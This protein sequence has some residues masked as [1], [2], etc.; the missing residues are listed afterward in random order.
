VG[1]VGAK[2]GRVVVFE[3]AARSPGY[4]YNGEVMCGLGSE[5]EAT[6]RLAV[7]GRKRALS[8]IQ[9]FAALAEGMELPP[10]TAVA[11]AA[12][13]QAEDGEEFQ[14]E[15]ERD[16]GIALHVIDGKEE[17]RLSAQGVLL[18]W[19]GAEGLICDIGGSSMEV[20]RVGNGRVWERQTSKL[21][22]LRLTALPGGDAAQEREIDATLANL[23]N[24][25]GPQTRLYLVGG[26]WR[27][28]ARLDMAR[29]SYPLA[30]LH[31]YRMTPDGVAATLDAVDGQDLETLRHKVG[32]SAAR[33]RLV[34]MAGKVLR[35]MMAAF[36][37]QDIVTSAYGIREGLLYEKMPHRVR[38]RDPL[39]EAARHME[40]HNARMPGFGRT[41][42]T[43]IE[44]LFAGGPIAPRLIKAACLLHDVSWRAHPDYRAEVCFDNA[45][46]GNLGG[47][48]HPGRVFLGLALLHRYRNA[49]PGTRFD[50]L[51]DLL[52]PEATRHAEVLGKAMRFGAMFS[53]TNPDRM[54][55][56]TW[57]SD[58]RQL[59]L[60]LPPHAAPL[61]GEVAAARLTS[62]GKALDADINVTR[63]EGARAT[64]A[65]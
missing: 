18:G 14:R 58:S 1:D 39:I 52:T 2:C 25:I 48:D 28:I 17:A 50:P 21:G 34:P 10:L 61:F 27:A 42:Y 45:T 37:T 36:G 49:R 43:F 60:E 59:G 5:M 54:G 47:I 30:V 44:P 22:P 55:R 3:G 31:D 38:A 35:R 16:T 62:L 19:P 40:A 41:L 20:A 7:E 33:I 13:R 63:I 6:G 56:L 9:R 8:A 51:L 53:L 23:V 11:T 4:F 57:D 46:R 64:P 12:V 32:L 29:R 15:I 65:E 26:S 24:E